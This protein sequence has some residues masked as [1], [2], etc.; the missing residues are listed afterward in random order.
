MPLDIEILKRA[1]FRAD[2]NWWEWRN[3]WQI[4]IN[5]DD[6]QCLRRFVSVYGL[7]RG[8]GSLV[9]NHIHNY[10]STRLEDALNDI[11]GASL[12]QLSNQLSKEL[13]CRRHLSYL[14]KLAAF[15]KPE[16]FVALDRFSKQGLISLGFLTNADLNDLNYEIFLERV[17]QAWEEFEF[18][19]QSACEQHLICWIGRPF[20]LRILD[21]YLMEKGGRWS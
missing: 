1:T 12:D 10:V 13:E 3:V 7:L 11:S 6:E 17:N 20:G 2:L 4:G 21:C 15:K 9:R 18:D 19:I 16:R 5:F 8:E 14:S